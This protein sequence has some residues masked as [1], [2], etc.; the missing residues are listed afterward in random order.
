MKEKA[1]ILKYY[2]WG[3]A[4]KDMGNLILEGF[5]YFD[6][7]SSGKVN[8]IYHTPVFIMLK[9]ASRE[10]TQDRAF[11]HSFHSHGFRNNMIY[12][13]KIPTK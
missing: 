7:T 6:L 12:S 8:P 3:V 1:V 13:M 5:T 9:V 4:L 2:A 11:K 10:L